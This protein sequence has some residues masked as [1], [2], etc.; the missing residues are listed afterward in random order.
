MNLLIIEDN[1]PMRR[2][3][4]SF[5]ADLAEMIYECGDGAQALLVYARHRPDWVLM[6][7]QMEPVDGLTATG[8]IIAA[9]PDARIMIVTDY[10]DAKMREAA[11][12]A[13]A[14]EYVAKENL[15]DVRRILSASAT[16]KHGK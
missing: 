9:F 4:K 6:D 2:V 7:I 14:T 12:L 10:N 16:E 1:E 11:H 15:F 5:V 3:I 8:Q 13:G